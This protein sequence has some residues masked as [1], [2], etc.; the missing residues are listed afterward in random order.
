MSLA[1]QNIWSAIVATALWLVQLCDTVPVIGYPV[2]ISLAITI[3]LFVK[4]ICRT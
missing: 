1:L 4:K 3:F 2:V